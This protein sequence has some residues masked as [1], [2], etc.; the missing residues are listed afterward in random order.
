MAEDSTPELSEGSRA[1]A[2]EPRA[3]DSRHSSQV[4]SDDDTL[5]GTGSE[6]RGPLGIGSGRVVAGR[7]LLRE[8]LGA[9][10]FG[11][12][13][14]GSDL[15]TEANVAVKLLPASSGIDIAR[16]RDESATLRFLRMPGVVDLLDEGV[17]PDGSAFLVMPVVTG[18]PFPGAE[19]ARGWVAV[20]PVL[21]ALL[22]TLAR[23]HAA[24]IVHR[25][26]K[27]ANVLV[28]EGGAVTV[29]DFGACWVADWLRSRG[30]R[31]GELGLI[32]TPQYLAPEQLEGRPGD[33]RSDLFAV[34][35]M[36][37][38]ALTGLRPRRD[39]LLGNDS[40][41]GSPIPRSLRDAMPE[42]I[43]DEAVELLER[44]LARHPAHRPQS[45]HDALASLR[46][47]AVE[48]A[49]AALVRELAHQGRIEESAMRA[50]FG[51]PE[52]VFHLPSDSAAALYAA[53]GADAAAALDVVRHWIRAGLAT[54]RDGRV[55]LTRR[56][57]ER[58]GALDRAPS[59]DA[60]GGPML[61]PAIA[62]IRDWIAVAWPA[63]TTRVLARVLRC[64]E[65]ALRRH[66][67]ELEERGAIRTLPDGR[68]QAVGGS[69]LL[70]NY[71]AG[72]L[73][74]MYAVVADA[75]VPGDLLRLP[76]EFRTGDVRRILTE[77]VAAAEERT[78]E[79]RPEEARYVLSAGLAVARRA[80]EH[81]AAEDAL[82]R[83]VALLALQEAS[84]AAY[85][86][87]L[88]EIGR[89]TTR[90]TAVAQLEALLEAARLAEG[91]DANRAVRAIEALGRLADPQLETWRRAA[92]AR[93]ANAM[94]VERHIELLERLDEDA[95]PGR[96][97]RAHS[98]AWWARVHYREGAFG[99]A[100]DGYTSSADLREH[101]H[102]ATLQRLNAASA[103]MEC[104]RPDALERAHAIAVR[105]TDEAASRRYVLIDA[106]AWW[107]RR[108][109][110]YR[111]GHAESADHELVAAYVELPNAW[112]ASAG[113][114]TEAAI[115]WRAGA[116][117]DAINIA[118]RAFAIASRST[119]RPIAQ[120]MLSFGVY[121]RAKQG[122]A[123]PADAA[124]ALA[125]LDL[126]LPPMLAAQSA[127]LLLL[128]GVVEYPARLHEIV[129]DG[130][131][132]SEG[133][134]DDVRRELLTAAECHAAI[135]ATASSA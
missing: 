48:D 53:A 46:P 63:T 87:A 111:L 35:T 2:P 13:F 40:F 4:G 108:A 123:D 50:L 128:S 27:P 93:A 131:A 54:L 55:W 7:Y 62:P 17:E 60:P 116:V 9:G 67:R 126:A 32:G 94:P 101:W 64:G 97:A 56:D 12:V 86:D 37:V 43:D 10:G 113:L 98:E 125:G 25:D 23:I 31:N 124:R 58:V 90:T 121:L 29:L 119:A 92:L 133:W 78:A 15:L 104:D 30:P 118:D 11:A 99:Q 114:C 8:Q 34:G 83:E 106:R 69:A 44:L 26:L 82:L 59:L 20:Q 14:A 16:F 42:D 79:G 41:A 102:D 38:E 105:A 65:A 132:A 61:P 112:L 33:A 85:R 88:Y 80:P 72:D 134:R 75:L 129:R 115:A 52:R 6:S 47:V 49:L 68:L 89:A 36:V 103:L 22:E 39:G 21:V 5:V 74:E 122:G 120:I 96:Q 28:A 81:R 77:V 18:C 117:E 24:G 70:A 130:L 45:A 57:L 110:A 3:R 91:G 84:E 51:G 107:I 95:P 1:T 76:H 66:A 109:T 135:E 100:A 19:R 71:A 127:A 73:A